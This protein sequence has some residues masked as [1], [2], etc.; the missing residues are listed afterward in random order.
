MGAGKPHVGLGAGDAPTNQR[1]CLLLAG[2]KHILPSLPVQ[3]PGGYGCCLYLPSQAARSSA[4]QALG[5]E[6]VA[7]GG[8]GHSG[9]Q[10]ALPTCP[11]PD[12]RWTVHREVGVE[13]IDA[14]HDMDEIIVGLHV[15]TCAATR[16]LSLCQPLC[17]LC[18]SPEP[19]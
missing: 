14:A 12:M 11:C 6:H 1:A 19:G 17:M 15:S 9:G 7:G 18:L 2:Q 4:K 16:H 5:T 3:E 10:V 8:W 13:W